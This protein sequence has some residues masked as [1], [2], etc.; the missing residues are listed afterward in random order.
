MVGTK[1]KGP[2]TWLRMLR[3]SDIEVKTCISVVMLC[4]YCNLRLEPTGTP[5][6]SG[7][8]KDNVNG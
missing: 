7:L 3:K 1:P 8:R 6:P 5:C 4:W 2:W